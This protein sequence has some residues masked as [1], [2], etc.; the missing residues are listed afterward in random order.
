MLKLLIDSINLEGFCSQSI[1]IQGKRLI[2]RLEKQMF[3][4]SFGPDINELKVYTGKLTKGSKRI[5]KAH[6]F[7]SFLYFTLDI[8][9]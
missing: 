4:P 1:Y 3:L 2:N 8:V 9:S 5:S 6:F 7:C